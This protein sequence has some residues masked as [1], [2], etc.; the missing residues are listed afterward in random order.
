[1]VLEE[2]K[3]DNFADVD[4]IPSDCNTDLN[5]LIHAQTLDF[6]ND[7]A[8]TESLAHILCK[9][10]E[11]LQSGDFVHVVL[12]VCQL[13]RQLHDVFLVVILNHCANVQQNINGFVFD[14]LVFIVK[15]LIQHSEDLVSSLVL[16]DLGALLLDQLDQRNKLIQQCN[17]NFALFTG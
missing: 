7:E 13:E 4:Q 8:L 12:V 3:G 5:V 2:I 17:F 16:F 11:D 1:M 6:W 15:Q 10:I 9:F 14:L